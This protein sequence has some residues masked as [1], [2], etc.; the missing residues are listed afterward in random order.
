V[1]LFEVEPIGH[2]KGAAKKPSEI[3]KVVSAIRKR[4]PGAKFEIADISVGEAEI[5]SVNVHH[6]ESNVYLTIVL[7]YAEQ[8]ATILDHARL[9]DESP[10]VRQSPL[11]VQGIMKRVGRAL[12]TE[13]F[14]VV[15]DMSLLEH[16]SIRSL[17]EINN[18][19]KED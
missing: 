5:Y 6:E 18:Y 13:A 14:E 17:V 9:K 3:A 11:S 16:F 4:V 7:N 12:K 19:I 8:T 1:Y 15:F 2:R 10:A